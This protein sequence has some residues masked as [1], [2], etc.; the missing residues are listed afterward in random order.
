MP[1]KITDSF[2]FFNEIDILKIRLN[3]LYEKVDQFVI[4]ESNITHS[5]QPKS[6]N[7]LDHK[8]EFMPWMDKITFLKYEPDISNLDFSKK[9]EAYN[10]TSASWKIETGQRNFLSSFINLQDTEDYAMVCDVDEIWDPLFADFIRSGQ[11]E[12]D[13][14]RLEM[15]SH[16]YFLNCVG[17]GANNSKWIHAFFGKVGHIKSCPSLSNIRVGHP[18]PIISA[19]GWH[20]SYL[21]GAEKISEKITAFAHQEINTAE[22]NNLKHL[23]HCIN[24]GIDHLNRP[25]HEWAFHPIGYYPES[26]KNEMEKFPHLIK[27]SLV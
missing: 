15:K 23:E 25:G 13:I 1:M 7:F 18:L 27:S 6:Y 8:T 21:G 22:I 11:C 20:F 12:Y 2:I 17:I 9:E 3:I 5:G 10:P 16:Q 26:L 14:A 19:A 24:L 4:C